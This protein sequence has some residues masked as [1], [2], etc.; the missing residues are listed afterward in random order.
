MLSSS[1]YPLSVALGVVC[2]A[3]ALTAPRRAS[4]GLPLC[5]P[6][7]FYVARD[8]IGMEGQF[9]DLSASLRAADGADDAGE[10]EV[11]ID[12]QRRAQGDNR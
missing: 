9:R 2:G 5:A 11:P 6:P 7:A 3:L 4:A 1:H 10:G 12:I 8:A